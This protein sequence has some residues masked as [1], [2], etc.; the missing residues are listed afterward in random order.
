MIE[1]LH[2]TRI[3]KHRKAKKKELPCVG[4]HEIAVEFEKVLAQLHGGGNARRL[5]VQL[6]AKLLSL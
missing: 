5:L 2:F 6:K 3:I 4:K 1:T